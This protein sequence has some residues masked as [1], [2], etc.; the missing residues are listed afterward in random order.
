MFKCKKG[1]KT[2]IYN[3]RE[4]QSFP[5]FLY[6]TCYGFSFCFEQQCLKMEESKLCHNIPFLTKQIMSVAK[7]RIGQ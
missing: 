3:S 2:R 4:R 5:K 1:L 6:L 7:S